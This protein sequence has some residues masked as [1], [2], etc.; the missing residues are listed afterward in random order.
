MKKDSKGFTLAEMLIVV[1]IIGILVSITA[2]TI[3]DTLEKAREA[4][5]LANI[6]SAISK[7]Q[8]AYLTDTGVDPKFTGK[9]DNKYDDI[10]ETGMTSVLRS[11]ES[12]G[13]YN[14]RMYVKLTQKQSGWQSKNYI[15][16]GINLKEKNYQYDSAHNCLKIYLLTSNPEEIK[17]SKDVFYGKLK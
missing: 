17:M 4:T 15:V 9:F 8:E 13:S 16:A 5:D 6:R 2:I 3:S 10:K 14:Y 1:A 7:I 12:D 11:K